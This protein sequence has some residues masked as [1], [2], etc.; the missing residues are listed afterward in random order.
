MYTKSKRLLS[1]F[2]ALL[3]CFCC[4]ADILTQPAEAA[5]PI[6]IAVGAA[7][8]WVLGMM[9]IQFASMQAAHD[10]AGAF[11]NSSPSVSADLETVASTFLITDATTKFPLTAAILPVV[12]RLIAAAK[13]FFGGDSG[14]LQTETTN[15]YTCGDVKVLDANMM[16]VANAIDV[17]RYAFYDEQYYYNSEDDCNFFTVNVNGVNYEYYIRDCSNS[18]SWYMYNVRVRHDGVWTSFGLKGRSSINTDLTSEIRTNTCEIG[19]L[20]SDCTE[21]TDMRFGFWPFS[22]KNV[23]YLAPFFVIQYVNAA[24]VVLYKLAFCEFPPSSNVEGFLQN[25]LPVTQ[26]LE[27]WKE[28]DVPWSKIGI[29]VD[30]LATAIEAL[31]TTIEATKEAILDLTDVYNSLTDT[32]EGAEEGEQ[33]QT[34][35]YIPSLEW[36]KKMLRDMGVTADLIN[37]ITAGAT[38]TENPSGS[39]TLD[40]VD[41]DI[42]QLPDLRDKFPFCVPF[43]LIGCFQALNAE[44]EPPRFVVPLV[45]EPLNFSYDIVVDFAPFERIAVVCRWVC[46]FS[47]IVFLALVTRKI[48]QA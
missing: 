33:E 44:P 14:I 31:Q 3:V 28:A 4:C 5:I 47:F 32:A 27:P 10:A 35:P 41:P 24:G 13:E 23:D 34:V 43:D 29:D 7:A 16:D 25:Y 11:Y 22:Y 40:E 26:V 36:L 20:K 46:T 30:A 37:K 48:I 15:V 17:Y 21:I 12:L 42:P 18:D 39:I 45:F 2:L 19:I 38:E 6:A 9:G 1:L 8:A